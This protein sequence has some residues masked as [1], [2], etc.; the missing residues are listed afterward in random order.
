ML[1]DNDEFSGAYYLAGYVIECALKACIA[2]RTRKFDFP[3]KRTA[4]E[5]YTH[6]LAALVRVA[7]LQPDLQAEI[8][9]DQQGFGPYWGLVQQWTEHTRYLIID[10]ST[11]ENLI[12][13]VSDSKHGVL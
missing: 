2:K 8:Q 11:A 4:L 13:A 10:R 12:E 5:S 3:D 9:N 7:G 6:D 1:L